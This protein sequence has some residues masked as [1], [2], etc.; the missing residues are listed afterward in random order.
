MT[1]NATRPAALL[2]IASVMTIGCSSVQ[3]TFRS[4]PDVNK[5]VVV[6]LFDPIAGSDVPITVNAGGSAESVEAVKHMQNDDFEK[7]VAV[8]QTVQSGGKAD[9]RDLFA[10]GVALEKLD[11]LEPAVEAYKA[12]NLKKSNDI[13]QASR[14]RASE[15]MR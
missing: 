11:R 13:Y 7:A 2:L 4:K 1:R 8:L 5:V 3:E 14:R 10:L 12:A 15:K 6:D 9:D